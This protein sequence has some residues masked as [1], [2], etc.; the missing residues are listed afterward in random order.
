[1][2]KN[3]SSQ[4]NDWATQRKQAIEKSKQLRDDRKYNLALAGEMSVGTK[5]SQF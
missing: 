4:V 5:L 2:K 1:M 3:V